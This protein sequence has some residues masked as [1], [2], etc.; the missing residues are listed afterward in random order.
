MWV[1]GRYVIRGPQCVYVRSL[2]NSRSSVYVYS[3]DS[4]A[5]PR[6]TEWRNKFL[7]LNPKTEFVFKTDIYKLCASIV[8]N[9]INKNFFIKRGFVMFLDGLQPR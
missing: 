9:D 8:Y 7:N 6:V 1:F 2:R 5:I 4:Q 3:K